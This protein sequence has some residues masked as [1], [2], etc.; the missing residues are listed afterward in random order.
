MIYQ[1][2]QLNTA[3]AMAPGVD[4]Q[5]VAPPAV[6][7]GVATNGYGL[8]GVASWGPVNSP[9]VT[10]SPS[11]NAAN[12]GNQTVRMRDLASAIA[13]ALQ[14]GQ[15]NNYGVR[16][17]DGTDT[18]ATAQLLDG[19]GVNGATITGMYTGILGNSLAATVAAGTQANSYKLTLALPGF[20][21]EVF[22]N[23]TQG[24]ASG[25]VTPGTGYTSTPTVTIS[26]P[27]NSSGTQ[28]TG[29]V[30]IKAVSASVGSGGTG[31]VTGDTITLSNGVVL[32]V[33]AASGVITAMTVKTAGS[34]SGGSA[35]TNPVAMVATSGAGTGA[36]ANLVWGLGVYTPSVIGS[37]YT[38][39]TA[40][41]NGGAGTGGSIA[42]ATSVWPNL[43]SAVNNGQSG[44]RA[45]SQI[46]V[47]TIGTSIAVPAAATYTLSG[48]TDGAAGVT[49]STLIGSN[50][51]PPTGMYCHQSTNVMTMNLVDHETPSHWGTI[52]TFCLQNGIFGGVQETPG[53]T[54][55][56]TATAMNT[57]GVD[58]Y[59]LKVL[60]GDWV[61][62][63][64]T[65][66][67]VQRLL[68][69][70]TFWGPMRAMLAPNQSTLNKEISCLIGTIRSAANQPYSDAE[71]LAACNGRLD[72]L[73]N[74]SAGGN[75][76]GFQTDRNTSSA[77]A[78]NSANYGFVIGNPQ[79]PDLRKEV[80]DSL[81]AFLT[82]LWLVSKYIGDVNNPKAVPFKITL[83]ASN[84]PD[85]NVTL[86]VMQALVQVKYQAI[87]R[88]F[89][90][91][92]QGG[93]SVQVTVQ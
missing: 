36:T 89:L 72:Y 63:Q 31:F 20:S 10:G 75:Y 60:N 73:A 46:A 88:T 79:T 68:G 38:S 48:G 69:P 55:A 64:D 67:N 41:L 51:A 7:A 16:V 4:V 40:T 87:V 65:V 5:I 74:P 43:V 80:I 18:A 82:N 66:N 37:G 30:S 83:N 29:S 91:S 77:A 14:I 12:W 92:L 21:G 8:V 44:V 32:T 56:T 24:V 90:I 62:W 52:S 22:D 13:I 93:S 23:L 76:F 49:D 59:G 9:L 71:A 42:L 6:V 33:T 85:A 70:A 15:T 11:A 17:T 45:A 58:S 25:T 50:T 28:A 26:A 81:S 3:G 57:A 39:A 61:Y 1:F 78:T 53:T 86:G 19:A 54:I 84:N 47:A 27:Q 2:G 34:I 35:P